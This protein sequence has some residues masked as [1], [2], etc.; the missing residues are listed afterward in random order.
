MG[1]VVDLKA[2]ELKNE[3]DEF[4]LRLKEGNIKRLIIVADVDTETECL[5]VDYIG[6]APGHATVGML[7][8]AQLL[9]IDEM[10]G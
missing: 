10:Y 6:C 7:G 3:F 1:K 2:D 5:E 4:Y 9:T 8:V